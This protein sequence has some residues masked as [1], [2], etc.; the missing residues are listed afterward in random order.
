MMIERVRKTAGEL[1]RKEGGAAVP[2]ALRAV[3]HGVK[4][5]LRVF[6][7]EFAEERKKQQQKS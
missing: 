4:E 1:I 2:A 7:K 3:T 5:A 6:P